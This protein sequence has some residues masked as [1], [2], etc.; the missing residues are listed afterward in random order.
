MMEERILEKQKIVGDEEE[1]TL[2]PQTLT[3]YI[4]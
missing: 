2:R 4:G 3:E 1:L